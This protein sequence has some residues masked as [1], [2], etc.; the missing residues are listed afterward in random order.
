MDTYRRDV[1]TDN[2]RIHLI[3]L[4]VGGGTASSESG[5]LVRQRRL[6][7]VAKEGTVYRVE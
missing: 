4:S 6:R 7:S 3:A 2:P 1:V 5:D